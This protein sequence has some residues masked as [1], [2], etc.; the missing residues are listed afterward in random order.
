MVDRA[1]ELLGIGALSQ[2]LG[3]SPSC[4]RRWEALGVIPEAARILGNDRRVYRVD[5]L[6]AIRNHVEAKRAAGRQRSSPARAA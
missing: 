2:V 4:I 1:S 5:D 3:V 6:A